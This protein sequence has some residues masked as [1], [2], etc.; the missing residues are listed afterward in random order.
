MKARI[1]KKII[2]IW[3]K[4][5]DKRFFEKDGEIK[6]VLIVTPNYN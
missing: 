6:K 5:C 2:K 4:G 3:C 1:A